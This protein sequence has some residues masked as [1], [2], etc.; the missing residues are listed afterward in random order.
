MAG[1]SS[2]F[3]KAGFTRPKYELEVNGRSLFALTVGSFE[4]YFASE[5][6]V[7]IVRKDF[8]ARGFVAA[9]C[10]AMGIA[11]YT[12]VELHE[13]TR[14]QAETVLRGI[15]SVPH[16]VHES[17]L[18]FNID[19]IRPGYTFP[20]EVTF[21][22]GY[23]EVFR[24]SGDNWSFVRPASALNCL[25]AQTTEKQRISDLCCTGLYYFASLSDFVT[26]CED[27]IARFAE[28]ER[29]WRELYIAP[30]YN[31]LIAGGKRIAYHQV[32][33]AQVLLSGTPD[34]YLALVD[35]QALA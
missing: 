21:A 34:E 33:A 12:I 26:V 15:M 8:E 4:R 23:L 16:L 29:E 20:A 3:Y 18:I 27:A 14:G 1:N 35:R 22:D 10:Q 31:T 30:M 17:L 2:R 5:H 24:T 9:S 11:T 32:P 13:P 7:F 28:F 19:T 6:F 25:V